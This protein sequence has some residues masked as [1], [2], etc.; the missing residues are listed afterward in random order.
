MVENVVEGFRRV[1]Q[2]NA[3]R[4]KTL[5]DKRTAQQ[6]KASEKIAKDIRDLTKKVED[7]S[8]EDKKLLQ[9]Q[10]S[11]LQILQKESAD[12]KARD[13]D[14]RNLTAQSL[15]ISRRRFE[16]A[17]KMKE[18][19]ARSREQLNDLGEELK[20]NGVKL[21]GNTQAAKNYQKLDLELKKKERAAERRAMPIGSAL[22]EAQ[23]DN[24]KRLGQALKPYL[25]KGS[26]LGDTLMG[27]GKSL[28]QKVTGGI[29]TL[30][31]IIKKGLFIGAI[32]A[33]IMFFNSDT[34]RKLKEES[35]PKLAKGLE[36]LDKVL[37][38]FGDAMERI[39]A[40]FLGT[41]GAGPG[42]VERKG[43]ILA[44][45]RQIGV[46]LGF[47]K[48]NVT[49]AAETLQGFNLENFGLGV[50]VAT[51]GR[52]LVGVTGLIASISARI[53]LA[54]GVKGIGQS[55][56]A[57]K[58]SA[59]TLGFQTGREIT[60]ASGTTFRVDKGGMLRE[61]LPGGATK[62]GPVENQ[63][64]LIQSLADEGTIKLPQGRFLKLL[65][66]LRTVVKRV[67]ILG[68]ALAIEDLIGLYY[69]YTSGEIS[70][71][72]ATARLS[73][74][75]FGTLG[76][77]GLGALV[78]GVLGTAGFPG[79]GTVL[80][81]IGGAIVGYTTGEALGQGLA[82]YALGLPVESF[83]TL[84]FGIGDLN[85]FFDGS[86][87]EDM[88]P[89]FVKMNLAD[90]MAAAAASDARRSL[91]SGD[92]SGLAQVTLRDGPGFFG[93][94][95]RMKSLLGQKAIARDLFQQSPSEL[96]KFLPILQE[97]GFKLSDLPSAIGVEGAKEVRSLMEGVGGTS[98]TFVNTGNS[99]NN[100][101][102][103]SFPKYMI[104]QDAVLQRLSNSLGF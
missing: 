55:G 81:G 101:S 28:K 59:R 17:Q 63:T 37:E 98:T 89:D 67:P 94:D 72:E 78:G 16:T 5:D 75:L 26:F 8:G 41:T 82:E 6:N 100:M 54:A 14:L 83:P 92:A 88:A 99:I 61:V 9:A 52:A 77:A 30:F 13:A 66:G 18:D 57:Q 4:T 20:K 21:D 102:S 97:K 64:K 31:G 86:M 58:L 49:S 62:G 29:D 25:G 12:R 23:K 24:A 103:T 48:D 2:E 34:F 68:Q 93:T 71:K 10:L 45:L 15:G 22:I 79:I 47:F 73:G 104:N 1:T 44:G 85:R 39:F 90:A 91:A 96:A 11:E 53:A 43:G 27:V 3:Q 46:E 95:T 36:N 87:Q 7:A 51:L 60:S 74:V 65:K 32:G 33:L 35:I 40:A 42:G 70:G 38:M 80:G 56:A 50:A 19:A 69:G 84:P 76:A